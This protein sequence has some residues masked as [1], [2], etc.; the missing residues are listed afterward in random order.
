VNSIESSFPSSQKVARAAFGFYAPIVTTRWTFDGKSHA[1][2]AAPIALAGFETPTTTR[3][4]RFYSTSAAGF[5]LGHSRIPTSPSS[6]PELISWLD[7]VYGKYTALDSHGGRLSIDGTLKAPGTP[8]T[9]G[10]S[11]NL[12]RS[13]RARDDLRLF[14]GTRF[15][16]GAL[17]AKLR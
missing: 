13:G 17:L 15:D 5:R 16:L 6:A 12:G 7:V 10:F 4:D 14:L 8:L 9:V 1:L 3:A 11:A 2:F